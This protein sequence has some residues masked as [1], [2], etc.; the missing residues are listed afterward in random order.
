METDYDVETLAAA[1]VCFAQ[2]SQLL[3][4]EPDV[5]A[6]AQ[7]VAERVFACAPFGMDDPFVCEGLALMDSWCAEAAAC[8]VGADVDR[9]ASAGFE[10]DAASGARCDSSAVLGETSDAAGL[11]ASPAFGDRVGA[12]Q[13]EWLRL[14]AGVGAP[15][16]SCLESFYVEPN[17]HMFGKNTLA[18]REQYRRHGLRIERM[19]SEPDDHLGLMLGFVS[20]LVDDEAVAWEAGRTDEA[21]ALA[22]EQ[23]EFLIA[24]VLPWLAAWRYAVEKHA[25][26]DYYRGVGQ[27]VF[28]LCVRYAQR[29]GIAFD[30]ASQ[31]F[32]RRA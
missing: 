18:V 1:E 13:R 31:S 14:F 17:S 8:A 21:E 20:R 30:P 7:Q 11:A 29:F 3:Y 25:A 23:R 32:K 10:A 9:G 12:L 4:C 24:H 28:G 2:A 5:D 19:H 26:S 6:V 16:A 27:L 22:S 15:E